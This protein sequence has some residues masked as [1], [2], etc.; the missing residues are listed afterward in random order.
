MILSIIFIVILYLNHVKKKRREDTIPP[1]RWQ[2]V[3]EF[4]YYNQLNVH[5]DIQK[6]LSSFSVIISTYLTLFFS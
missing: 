4:I 1:R 2:A 3:N 5:T 6:S